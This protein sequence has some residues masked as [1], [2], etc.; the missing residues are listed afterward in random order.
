V[1]LSGGSLRGPS[2]EVVGAVFV[3]RDMRRER[4]IE[5]MK[6]DFLANISHE[7]RTPLTPIKGYAG[8]LQTRDVPPER[9]RQ[10]AGE[11]MAGVDQLERVITQLVHFATMAA[12]RLSLRPEP[13]PVRDLL[14]ETV[15]RWRGRLDP[16]HPISR[17]VARD[18]ALVVGDRRY[19]EQSL[20]ELIDNAVKY[21]PDGG[22][23]TLT[24]AACEN[25]SGPPGGNGGPGAWVR[26]TVADQ[27]VGIDPGRLDSLFADFSQGD[28]SATRRFGGLGL[29]L[30]LVD[31][32]VRAH[33]GELEC[34]SLP[35]KGSRFSI[36]LPASAPAERSRRRRRA[37]LRAQGNGR[38][39][40]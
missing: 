5:R 2:D 3:L 13:V 22:R 37:P 27:G 24:A 40:A 26:I 31:R 34:E 15:D 21:S 6:T 30:T 29:G 39:S 9:A 18:V 14:D 32:I 33:E 36:V 10:F 12:G 20:D 19:L 8:M 38:G 11:I 35:G 25:G 23:V 28:S 16:A 1:A 7:M 17:R 4:E